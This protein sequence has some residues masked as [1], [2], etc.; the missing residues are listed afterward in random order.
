MKRNSI[1]L[2]LSGIY[3]VLYF[4]F[5]FLFNINLIA[6]QDTDVVVIEHADSLSGFPIEGENARALIGHVRLRHGKTIM[7]CDRAIQYF[8]SK[9]VQMEGI[10]EVRDDTTRLVGSRGMYYSDSKIAEIYDRVFL[11]EPHTSLH[12]EYGKYFMNDRKAIFKKNV[13]VEDT[14]SI[15]Y[16]DE[17]VYYR[18]EEKSIADGNVKLVNSKNGLTIFGGHFENF[19]KEKYSR[20]TDQPRLIQ[21][22]TEQ[23]GKNDTLVV[24]AK[25]LESFQDTIER[26]IATDSVRIT[27]DSLDAEGGK[28]IYLT[29]LDS[30]ILKQSPFIWYNSGSVD[31]TQ[32]SGETIYIKLKKRRLETVYV[33][34]RAVAISRADSIHTYRFNQ[35]TGQEIVLHFVDDKIKQVDVN[36]TATSLYYL[37]DRGKGNGLNKSTGDQIRMTFIDGKI[38]KINAISNIEG[39]YYPEKLVKN[40]EANFNLPEFNWRERKSKKK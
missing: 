26:L 19:K 38:D 22:D 28:C 32:V 17:L 13:I 35:L 16:A 5:C 12:A 24:V 7:T 11:E 15:L 34:E 27:R 14:T 21:V 40:K 23:N 29:D 8:T 31:D 9:K 10:V 4:I 1:T 3:F 33:R 18:N 20:I 30:I 6:Q 2:Y 25:M 37:F 36:M 39:Q